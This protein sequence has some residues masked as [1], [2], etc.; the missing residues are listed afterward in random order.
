MPTFC[1]NFRKQLQKK[2]YHRNLRMQQWI[3]YHMQSDWV[4]SITARQK[5]AMCRKNARQRK[6]KTIYQRMQ[7]NDNATHESASQRR[8]PL[9]PTHA[10]QI[11]II[12]IQQK[13]TYINKYVYMHHTS[14]WGMWY[15]G[16]CVVVGSGSHNAATSSVHTITDSF[17][18]ATWY[19]TLE[20]KCHNTHIPN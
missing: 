12:C 1:V 2:R 6:N 5:A 19:A 8:T 16:Q 14:G 9:L 11:L 13:G 3:A 17:Q 4:R 7:Q 18:L 10:P 15:R 20:Q